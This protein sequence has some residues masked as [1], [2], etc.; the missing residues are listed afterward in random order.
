MENTTSLREAVEE[1]IAEVSEWL[2][3]NCTCPVCRFEIE[4][5]DREY[6]KGR[7]ERMRSRKARYRLRELQAKSIRELRIIL[8]ELRISV[9][10]CVEKRDLIN[11]LV[12]SSKVEIIQSSGAT[13]VYSSEDLNV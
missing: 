4:T 12:E 2:K 10:G 5:D 13:A 3:K 6:E 11:R 1:G 8:A 9:E 7:K